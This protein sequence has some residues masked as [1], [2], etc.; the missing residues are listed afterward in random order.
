MSAIC[1]RTLE[2]RIPADTRY[3][4]LVRR[5]VRSLA[6]SMGF[7]RE[8]VADVEVAV[9]EAVTNSMIH[10]SPNRDTS[11]VVVKCRA[12]ARSLVVE[13]E[14]HS[15]CESL[16]APPESPTLAEETGRGF[17]IMR[18]L[19]DD[20]RNSRTAHGLRIRLTKQRR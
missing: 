16:P 14:D 17:Y 8:D 11:A 10:G 5:G 6:E 12:L 13:V 15:A 9:S 7:P 4:S 19:M 18:E 2:L 20:C 1:A 3:V